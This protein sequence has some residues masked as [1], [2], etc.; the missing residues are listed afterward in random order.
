[1]SKRNKVALVLLAAA[2]AS[3]AAD[4]SVQAT[5][6]RQLE[7]FLAFCV[8]TKSAV[9]QPDDAKAQ[10]GR[11]IGSPLATKEERF[12][13]LM[14]RGRIYV[15]Q[16][17]P[18][19]AQ[20]DFKSAYALDPNSAQAHFERAEA[21]WSIAGAR[22]KNEPDILGEYQATI[23]VDPKHFRAQYRLGSLLAAKGKYDQAIDALSAALGVSPDFAFAYLR[24]GHVYSSQRKYDLALKDY[25]SA[26][27]LSEK[28]SNAY[29]FDFGACGT[30]LECVT[31][32]RQTALQNIERANAASG[33]PEK[34]QS[35]LS[36][37][38]RAAV[39]AAKAG[40]YA[41]AIATLN[42]LI[43]SEPAN[44]AARKVRGQAFYAIRDYAR[45]ESDISEV[46]KLK[47]DDVFLLS[48]RASLYRVRKY[49]E[50]AIQDLSKIL[51]LGAGDWETWHER[52]VNYAEQ[53]EF[54]KALRDFGE[55][56]KAVKASKLNEAVTLEAE[57]KIY[58]ERAIA[59]IGL[60]QYAEAIDD[61]NVVMTGK[62]P[63]PRL[64]Y[65]RGNSRA[66]LG[67][68]TEALDDAAK[69]LEIDPN[70]Q[71][72]K[73]LRAGILRVRSGK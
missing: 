3:A 73:D 65:L 6:K 36:D 60:R 49:Y 21:L 55:A 25:D 61:L 1:M 40:D 42:P 43:E 67:Q 14:A 24:R 50:G 18:A 13:A 35:Q 5:E 20:E 27:S 16:G 54:G 47:E 48:L 69:A 2:C 46:L 58:A 12:Q 15:R 37:S 63:T 38:V 30:F 64:Y 28:W 22:K 53:R 32:A 52:G 11:V 57:H 59:L 72:A 26:L 41:K 51:K 19:G 44:L 71:P 62:P 33:G 68:F 29:M 7:Q 23:Q 8:D 31:K 39:A 17:Q 10:C 66:F 56:V 4:A 9:K 34:S 45:A 70:Y